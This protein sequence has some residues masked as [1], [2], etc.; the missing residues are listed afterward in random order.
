MPDERE[1]LVAEL[2]A[3]Y[4]KL[5]AQAPEEH[6]MDLVHAYCVLQKVKA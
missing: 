2:F 3:R 1:K 4:E 5:V 6:G